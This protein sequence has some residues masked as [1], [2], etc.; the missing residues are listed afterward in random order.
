MMIF[1]KLKNPLKR[2]KETKEKKIT[3]S[4]TQLKLQL[5]KALI[6]KS[7]LTL[8]FRAKKNA[9]SKKNG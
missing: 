8:V 3:I 2:K 6:T 1:V 4:I 9:T 7:F 5:R